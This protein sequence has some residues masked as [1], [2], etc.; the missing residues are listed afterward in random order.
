MAFYSDHHAYASNTTNNTESIQELIGKISHRLDDLARQWEVVFEDR[1]SSYDPY[2]RG[3][4]YVAPTCHI[5]GFQGHSPAECPMVTLTLQ[6]VLAWASLNSIAHTK[7]IT[8]TSGLKTRICHIG[9]T[10][11][12]SHRL[13]LVIICR[14]LGTMRRA[15][16]MHH[17]NFI[18]LLLIYHSTRRCVQWS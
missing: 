10:T 16:T 8:H 12:R 18:Q 17:K 13:L 11:L 15:T 5:C 4:P 2:S 3:H 1:P 6:I 14:D 7:A 9:A